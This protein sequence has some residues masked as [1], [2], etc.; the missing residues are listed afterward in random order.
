MKYAQEI[1]GSPQTGFWAFFWFATGN[2]VY[3]VCL[4]LVLSPIIVRLI[5]IRKKK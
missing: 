4:N 2:F 5:N 1:T 3:E